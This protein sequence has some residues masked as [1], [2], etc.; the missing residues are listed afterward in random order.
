MA[1]KKKK[2]HQS[3][4]AVKQEIAEEI[5][6]LEAIYADDFSLHDDGIGF[7][8]LV[9]P[10]P[11]YHSDNHCSIE[12]HV[13]SVATAAAVVLF[14]TAMLVAATPEGCLHVCWQSL[15]LLQLACSQVLRPPLSVHN[16]LQIHS[17]ISCN[18]TA[19]QAAQPSGLEQ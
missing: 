19:A 10:H 6:A 1:K 2:Q 12:L 4:A 9:V 14:S 16:G 11:G 13:R 8:L 15:L 18:T 3:R 5:L 7:Q 17:A